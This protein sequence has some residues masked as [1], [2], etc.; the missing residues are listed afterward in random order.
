MNN[1]FNE[2]FSH[3]PN[4]FFTL[5]SIII[6][7]GLTIATFFLV[8][9]FWR[10]SNS[11]GKESTLINLK[12]EI[13]QLKSSL[14]YYKNF[15]SKLLTVIENSRLFIHSINDNKLERIDVPFHIQRIVESLASDVKTKPGEK[16]RCGFWMP[17][18][19]QQAL[20][21]MHGSSGFPAH[22]IGNRKL[23]Y[24][25]SIAGRCFRK[26][27]LIN[28]VDVNKDA[29]YKP[30]NS[31]YKSLICVPIN[32]F[33]VLTVDGIS[34]FD[35]SVESIAELYGAMIENVLIELFHSDVSSRE[36]AYTIS[37]EE[38]KNNG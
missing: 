35:K 15:S 26:K 29:D 3:T 6:L 11:L 31:N 21:L 28:C 20:I 19:K 32:D 14:E 22:Y 2:L 18:D 17:D 33:G 27:E 23:G 38:E 5:S 8:L 7:I 36:F 10:F 25:Q 13:Y 4:W 12:D 16:H 9:G 30:S 37:D 34:P 1:F 24:D